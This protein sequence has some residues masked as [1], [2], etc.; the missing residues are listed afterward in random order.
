MRFVENNLSKDSL[1][2]REISM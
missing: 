1:L 2:L